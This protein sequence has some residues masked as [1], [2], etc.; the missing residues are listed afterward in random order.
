MAYFE[1]L[2]TANVL[3]AMA[4]DELG[5]AHGCGAAALLP[6]YAELKRMY[7][8]PKSRGRGIGDAIVRFLERQAADRGYLNMMLETGINQSQALSFYERLGYGRRGSF[9]DYRSD[10]VSIFMERRIPNTGSQTS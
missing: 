2:R 7:V 6:G 9:G 1:A 5:L 8:R 10:S 3:F 4:R